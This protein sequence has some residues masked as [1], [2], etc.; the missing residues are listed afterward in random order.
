MHQLSET[1]LLDGRHALRG[2]RR[3]P[4]FA[5]AATSVLAAAIGTAAAI[6]AVVNAAF[7]RPLPYSRPDQ[8][9][10][11]DTREPL[12]TAAPTPL[13]LSAFHFSRWRDEQRAFAA[14]EA[15]GP[16]T[17]SLTGRGQEPEPLRGARVSSGLFGLLG[18][19]PLLGRD[20]AQDEERAG[21]GVAMIGYG[22][23][24]RRFG[25]DPHVVGRTIHLDEEPREI[26]GVMPRGFAPA[27]QPGEVWIPL[28]MGPE[29]IAP[30]MARLRV[31]SAIG[32]LRD[33]VTVE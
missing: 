30:R 4:A 20:F 11:L 15:F 17:I 6:F 25:G 22:L 27:M 13:A 3:R 16:G 7:L 1:L 14:V 21:S 32:R 9:V 5:L 12:G 18:V 24:Q 33:G 2:L 23:W 31:L 26:I 28:A 10:W 29:D 19:S 8:L